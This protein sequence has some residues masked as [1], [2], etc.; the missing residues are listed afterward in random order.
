MKTYTTKITDIKR[1]WHL[2]DANN[3][4]LGRL[5]TKIALLLMGKH[6]VYFSPHL[7][8][9]DWVV[10][11]HADK[12]VVTGRKEK[13]K[14]YRWHTGYPKG[15]R[16]LSFKQMMDKNP[17]KIIRHAV[18]GMLPINK[19]RDKRLARLKIF[20]GPKHTFE[21]KFNAKNQ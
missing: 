18:S 2:L 6:K 4:V 17:E 12:I 21:D 10:V 8:C 3:Q 16:Q 9:G 14:M 19:L 11:V 13:Q 15:F 20:A 1:K 7:D 5:S